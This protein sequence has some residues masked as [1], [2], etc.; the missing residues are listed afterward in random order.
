MFGPCARLQY[1]NEIRKNI[2]LYSQTEEENKVSMLRT[3]EWVI[4]DYDF[5]IEF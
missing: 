5:V 1:L 2:L 3:T 4:L